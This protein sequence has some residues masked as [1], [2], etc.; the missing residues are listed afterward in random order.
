MSND[1]TTKQEK[2]IIKCLFLCLAEAKK[3]LEEK[4]LN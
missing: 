2:T 4:K 3:K 1:S